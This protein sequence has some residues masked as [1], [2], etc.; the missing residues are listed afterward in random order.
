MLIG[1]VVVP[2]PVGVWF[3]AGGVLLFGL[4]GLVASRFESNVADSHDGT[5]VFLYRDS[6]IAPLLGLLRS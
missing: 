1:L 2:F 3:L 5:D 6:T 4:S